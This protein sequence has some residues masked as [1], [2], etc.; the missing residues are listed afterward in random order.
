MNW[1]LVVF[2]IVVVVGGYYVYS[3][4]TVLAG[5]SSGNLL[6]TT[7]PTVNIPDIQ[8]NPTSYL[9]KTIYIRGTLYA[10]YGTSIELLYLYQ[11]GIQNEVQQYFSNNQ[12][13]WVLPLTLPNQPNRQWRYGGSYL[14]AGHLL[15]LYGCGGSLAYGYSH[16]QNGT[17]AGNGT[18][19]TYSN[20]PPNNRS[21]WYCTTQPNNYGGT[22]WN[23][24]PAVPAQAIY[25]F[26][27]TN[28]T[29]LS[30]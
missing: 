17:C 2:A 13:D 20:Y 6:G 25:Y 8:A 23:C 10:T 18:T 15:I 19:R 4:P 30:G 21:K 24:T 22:N 11:N 26:N 9:N 5:I 29:L 1:W 3:N 28:A 27:A 7:Q 14:F 16:A 12:T